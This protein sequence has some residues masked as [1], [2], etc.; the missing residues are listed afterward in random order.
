MKPLKYVL[1]I[2]TFIFLFHS[3][4]NAQLSILLG[5]SIGWTAPTV[6]YS[7]ETTDYYS[8]TRYALGS[9]IN[10]GAM[11]KL[12]LGPINFNLSVLY[13]PLSGSGVADATQPNNSVEI[14]QNLFTIGVGT[15][16]GF[17]IPMSPVK[18]YIGF[19]LLFTTISGSTKFQGVQ[20]VNSST[21]DLETASRTGLGFAAG[22]EIKLLSTALDVSL[23]YN[24]INLF[25]KSYD[26][27]PTG[28]RDEAYKYL[29][30]AKDPNYSS[31]D[32]K[33]PVG[34]DRTIATIQFQLGILFGL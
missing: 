12:N 8:G 2:F 7:G 14:K 5:P 24:L 6:D 11:G 18:P 34:T 13:C 33:H 15:Q 9:G 25:N 1:F 30:D 21:I 3:T 17:S 20:K 28:T 29:N 16:Y 26:G 22:V 31:S 19:D 4:S 10:F 23:R 32:D 27:S